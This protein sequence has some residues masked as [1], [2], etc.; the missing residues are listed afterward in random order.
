MVEE[1][2]DGQ[3]P[4]SPEV[5]AGVNAGAGV[6]NVE[7]KATDGGQQMDEPMAEA[8]WPGID[9]DEFGTEDPNADDG[10]NENMMGLLSELVHTKHVGDV[11]AKQ[12]C[13]DTESDGICIMCRKRPRARKEVI[14]AVECS[15]LA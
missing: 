8:Q 9:L 6:T 11:Q 2:I 12:G 10:E 15:T 3:M 14:C 5:A 13:K 1:P 4:V 7:D